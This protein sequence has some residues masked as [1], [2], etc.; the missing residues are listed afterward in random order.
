MYKLLMFCLILFSSLKLTAADSL[1]VRFGVNGNIGA[2]LP[3]VLYYGTPNIP[4]CCPEFASATG[5][6]YSIGAIAEIPLSQLFFFGIRGSFTTIEVDLSKSETTIGLINNS[7]GNITFNHAFTAIFPGIST[8]T[9]FGWKPTSA[10]LF[11]TGPGVHIVTSPTFSQKE[12]IAQGTPG[13]FIDGKRLRNEYSGTMNDAQSLNWEWNIIVGYDLSLDNQRSFFLTPEIQYTH[14]LS[15]NVITNDNSF[16]HNSSLRGGLAFKYRPHHKPEPVIIPTPPPSIPT[17]TPPAPTPPTASINVE[18]IGQN[19]KSTSKNIKIEEFVSTEMYPLLRYIFFDEMSAS[20]PS[21]YNI[22][23]RTDVGNINE[24]TLAQKGAMTLYYNVLNIIGKRMRE[25]PQATITLTGCLSGSK[26]ELNMPKLAQQRVETIAQYLF[27]IWGISQQRVRLVQRTLPALPAN[28]A[29]TEGLEENRRVEISSDYMGITDPIII[30]DTIIQGTSM[31]KYTPQIQ[32]KEGLN[33]WNLVIKKDNIPLMEL[34]EKTLPQKPV[35]YNIIQNNK[36]QLSSS[37]NLYAVLTVTDNKNQTIKV[38]A[39]SIPYSVLSVTDKRKT[40]KDDNEFDRYRLL[41]FGYDQSSLSEEHKRI[42][43]FIQPRVHNDAQIIIRGSTDNIGNGEYNNTLSL[44][45]AKE[46]AKA[47]GLQ[48]ETMG[49]GTS[50]AGYDNTLPEG[51]FY[52]RTVEI[53]VTNPVR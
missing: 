42:L 38:S 24:R 7:E 20:I 28:I 31:V 14:S 18:I 32:A 43:T 40:R 52:N 3:S 34:S 13:T 50:G 35:E 22:L 48:A 16:W 19:S 46:S 39:D 47:L 49:V 33:N 21:R 27:E 26:E 25:N 53:Q 51:R 29:R 10:L 5:F 41:L 23:S 36:H 17:P 6:V 8:T 11:A 12:S 9:M 37:G 44:Q 2:A 4:N 15:N 30:T 1:R 45:R